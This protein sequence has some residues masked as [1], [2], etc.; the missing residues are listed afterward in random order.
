MGTVVLTCRERSD[1]HL[2]FLIWLVS[3]DGL[4]F[5][6]YVISHCGCDIM[7]AQYQASLDNVCHCIYGQ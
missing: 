3:K 7:I 5:G 6:F 4:V 2:S 1:G